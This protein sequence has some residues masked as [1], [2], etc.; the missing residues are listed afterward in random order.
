MRTCSIEGCNRKHRARGY[1]GLH[2]SR[3]LRGVDL[4]PSKV[5]GRRGC[6]VANC[7]RP[8]E[9]LGYCKL[10]YDRYRNGKADIDAPVRRKYNVGDTRVRD[11]NGY[12]EEKVDD[13]RVWVLQHRYLMEL[14][15]DRRLANGESVH[16]KNGIRDDNRIE[17]LE[18]WSTSQPYGQRV[19]D[20]VAWAREI[21]EI[22]GDFRGEADKNA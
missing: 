13:E 19:E 16:H 9:G 7:N 21:L 1:C 6:K 5:Y 15:L 22:Y 4:N 11:Q 12:I 8:H 17:N 14:Y 18:L 2:Y 3:F 10:H 20:K